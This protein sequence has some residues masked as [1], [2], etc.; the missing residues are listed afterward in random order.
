[1]RNSFFMIAAAALA[2]CQIAEPIPPVPQ[3]LSMPAPMVSPSDFD[4]VLGDEWTGE[5]TYLDYS[6]GET[7]AIPATLS[8][9]PVDGRTVNY[10]FGYPGEPQANNSGTWTISGDGQMID[11]KP[12]TSRINGDEGEV[13]LIMEYTGE[14]NDEPADITESLI[15][16]ANGIVMTKQVKTQ[17][18]ERPFQRNSFAFSR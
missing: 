16:S 4:L 1:M 14:D 18:A 3:G 15:L 6:S 12:V 2:A 13:I 5:L 7:V 11:D 8:V 10:A 17:S 9:G